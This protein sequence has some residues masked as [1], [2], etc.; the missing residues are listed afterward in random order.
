M[1]TNPD[2]DFLKQQVAEQIQS[3]S[4]EQFAIHAQSEASFNAYIGEA[5]RSAAAAIGL[6]IAIPLRLVKTMATSLWDGFK[7]GW[8][9]GMN[10]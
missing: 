4:N 2:L 8:N 5:F 1:T 3:M 9:Q 10:G 7:D 6:I